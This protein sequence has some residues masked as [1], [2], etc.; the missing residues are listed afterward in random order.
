M[1]ILFMSTIN[2]C[3][4]GNNALNEGIGQTQNNHN[5]IKSFTIVRN[6]ERMIVRLNYLSN[7]VSVLWKQIVFDDIKIQSCRKFK[8]KH[9][10]DLLTYSLICLSNIFFIYNTCYNVMY[11]TWYVKS[12]NTL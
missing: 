10:M 6:L 4:P 12:N 7:W 1:L 8:E 5:E 9:K 11:L 3:F 2:T